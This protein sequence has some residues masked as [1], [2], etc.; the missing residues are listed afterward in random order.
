MSGEI[1]L[2]GNEYDLILHQAGALLV[3]EFERRVQPADELASF[4][5]KA[6]RAMDR[7]KRQRS[8]DSLLSMATEDIR[9]LTGFDRVMAYRFRPDDSGEVVAEAVDARFEPFIGRR[10]PAGDIPAQARRL[11]VVNTLRMISDI[12]SPTVAVIGEADAPP[13]DMSHAVLRSVS[14]IH[15]EYL[16]NMGVGASMSVSI[17]VQGRLWGMIACH[18]MAPRQ[19]PYSVRMACDVIAQ[20]LAANVHTFVTRNHGQRVDAAATL[21]AHQ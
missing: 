2:Q 15:I 20:I 16:N 7:L 10:Y 1:S 9:Q 19:V 11:Y 12:G 18:H 5:L 6:H 14:P 17:V 4:A 21:R 3:A 13:L 8:I